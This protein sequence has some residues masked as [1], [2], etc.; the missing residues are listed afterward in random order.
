MI[1]TDA[2][3]EVWIRLITSSNSRM[4]VILDQYDDLQLDGKWLT[5]D[6]RSTSFSRARENIVGI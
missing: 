1:R 6:E 5:D 3:P 4:H 2:D